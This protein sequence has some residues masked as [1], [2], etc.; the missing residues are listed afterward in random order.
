MSYRVR[1]RVKRAEGAWPARST[2]VALLGHYHRVMSEDSGRNGRF[3]LAGKVAVVTGAS[4]GLGSQLARALGSAGASLVLAARRQGPLDALVDELENA[5]ALRT[6][7]TDDRQRGALVDAAIGAFGRIDVLV[8][9][10]GVVNVASAEDETLDAFRSVLEVN[11]VAPFA[12]SQLCARHMLD[13]GGGSIVNVASVLGVVGCGQIPQA[14]YA[15]SKGALVN[16]TRELG[17]QWARRGIRV[18]AVAPAWFESEMTG[19]MLASASGQRWVQ[20]HTPMGRPGLPGE[21]DGAVVFLASDASS[22][23]T[24]QVLAVDGGWTAV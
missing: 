21:L 24:G 16:L 20:R 12:L 2:L 14:S 9:N 8:N 3:S 5:I 13:A 22:Y 10:A 17:A 19:E 6:D 18:N 4:S 7:V 1:M 23:V 15:A 11:L